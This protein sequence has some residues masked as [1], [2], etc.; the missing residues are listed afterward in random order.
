MRDTKSL[1]LRVEAAYGISVTRFAHISRA[2][3]GVGYLSGLL[4]V[5][6]WG[7]WL[8][9]GAPQTHAKRGSYMYRDLEI[10]EH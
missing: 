2:G 3:L 4:G 5:G 10:Q 6:G 7:G 8:G 1:S 9:G